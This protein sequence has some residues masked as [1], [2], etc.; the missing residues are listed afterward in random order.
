MPNIEVEL[1]FQIEVSKWVD[2]HLSIRF[3]FANDK[4]KWAFSCFDIAIEHHSSIVALSDL[5]LYGSALAL[6]RVQYEA[7]IRG[8]WLRYVASENDL[9][10]FKRDKVKPNFHELI[11]AVETTRGIKSGLLS[12]IKDKQWA[13][14]NSFTHTGVEA[15]LRRMGENTTGYDN[16]NSEDITNGLRFSGLILL[17]CASE[18]AIL[19]GNEELIDKT[20]NLLQSYKNK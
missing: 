15:L 6:F 1:E 12:H 20:V 11:E 16:Y 19:T 13:I 14:F 18:M 2:Q 3:N 10:R 7:F 8:L 9:S 17:L 4:D 5:N